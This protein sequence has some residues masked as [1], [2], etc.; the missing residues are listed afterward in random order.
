[1]K[2]MVRTCKA[3][4]R[5]E[6]QEDAPQQTEDEADGQTIQRREGV[7]S[8]TLS[9]AITFHPGC[10]QEDLPSYKPIQPL[11]PCLP[12]EAEC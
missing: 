9:G 5:A 3:R 2:D 10:K 11:R 8:T 1:M 7:S 4:K 12:E 6:E